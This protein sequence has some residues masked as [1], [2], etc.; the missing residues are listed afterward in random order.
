M[1]PRSMQLHNDVKAVGNLV[2]CPLNRKSHGVAA[3]GCTWSAKQLT[4]FPYPL[5]AFLAVILV[6]LSRVNFNQFALS[7]ATVSTELLMRCLITFSVQDA[8]DTKFPHRLP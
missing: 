7:H 4:S 5:V 3:E 8:A 1:P 6:L 2:R